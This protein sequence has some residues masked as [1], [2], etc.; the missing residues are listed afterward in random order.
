MTAGT[1]ATDSGLRVEITATGDDTAL[2]GIQ[3]LVVDAQNSSSRAQRIADRAAALLFWF[4]LVSAALTALVWTLVGDPDAAVVRSI[5][6]L[7]IACPHALGLAIR[8][9]SRS[10]RSALPGAVCSSR[11]AWRSRA[12]APSTPCCSTRRAR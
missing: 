6:V 7:V 4:A 5:T 9:S 12:C 10:P 3:R 8:W 11:T 2:A 1:V